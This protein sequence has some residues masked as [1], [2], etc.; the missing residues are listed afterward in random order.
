MKWLREGISLEDVFSQV[1]S[2]KDRVLLTDYDGTL[3]PFVYERDRAIPYPG[4]MEIL[5][6]IA[7]AP[8]SRLIM[9]SGRSLQDLSRI[10][11]LDT[12]IEMWGTHG[13]ERQNVKGERTT[14]PIS[15]SNREA[16]YEVINWAENEEISSHLEVKPASVALHWRGTDAR[17]RE[18]L[19][20]RSA[21]IM[22]PIAKKT[23]MELHE[24]DGGRELRVPGR[25]K[26]H[27]VKAILADVVQEESALAYIG[28]DRTDEDAYAA[29]GNRGLRILV[30][31]EAHETRADMILRPPRELRR[32][33][34][35][36]LAALNA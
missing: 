15:D 23:M 26:G 10:L 11:K 17:V 7:A 21:T 34:E 9:I 2:A 6:E 33:L 1:R 20:D 36:W 25:D 19:M 30:R 29:I 3:A 4:I 35:G 8:R 12:P 32:F 14:W 5:N 24:F 31:N 13:W 16:L 18:H 22:A 28:D 27:A